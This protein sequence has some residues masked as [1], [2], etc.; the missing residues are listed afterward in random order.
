MKRGRSTH[1]A[2]LLEARI[3]STQLWG[4]GVRRREPDYDNSFPPIKLKNKVIPIKLNQNDTSHVFAWVDLY[5]LNL[6]W[7]R[8]GIVNVI[9]ATRRIRRICALS[10]VQVIGRAQNTV[11]EMAFYSLIGAE[12]PTSTVYSIAH[13]VYMRARM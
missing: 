13:S 10:M 6:I 4:H 9:D 7:F 3:S 8:A 11:M 1:I 2:M 12:K 5:K